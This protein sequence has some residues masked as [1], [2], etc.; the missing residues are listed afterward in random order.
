MKN[1]V[2]NILDNNNGYLLYLGRYFTKGNKQR[3]LSFIC[4]IIIAD[5]TNVC[6]PPAR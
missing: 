1:L 5:T 3:V 2:K 6:Y 4:A